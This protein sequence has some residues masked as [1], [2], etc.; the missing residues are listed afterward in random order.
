M[1]GRDRVRV[2]LIAPTFGA[3]GG[4]EAFV[5]ALAEALALDPRIDVRVCLKRARRCVV[6]PPLA[7]ECRAFGITFCD[8]ASREMWRSIAWADVVHSQSPSPD[9]AVAARMLGKPLV[10][11]MHNA[12]PRTPALRRWSWQ[13]AARLAIVRWYNSRFVWN[14]WEG[15][16]RLPGSMRRPPFSRSPT[17]VLA[18]EARRGFVFVGRLVKGKGV[19]ILLDAYAQAEL[20]P[21]EWPLT[22]LGDGP[23][24]ADLEQRATGSASRGIHFTG[25]VGGEA[26]NRAIAQ[27]RWL[28]VPSNWG[29]PYGLVAVEARHAGVPCLITRDGGLP[30]AGGRDALVCEP[31]DVG[32]L[33]DALCVAASMSDAEYRIRSIRTRKDLE[34]EVISLAS[35]SDAYVELLDKAS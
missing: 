23:L 22:I 5:F 21:A 17:D 35:Y 4:I 33:R 11:S 27:A 16:R 7:D 30:E 29:E 20:D 1:S 8:R 15:D 14:T 3:Y 32:A 31:G 26:K 12:L 13:L 24:R 10:I 2:L 18:P 19:E 34:T 9:I 28:V 25:F 6:E